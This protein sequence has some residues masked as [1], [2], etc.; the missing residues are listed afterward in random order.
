MKTLFIFLILLAGN[1]YA[2]SGS[3]SKISA[4]GYA[5]GDIS[6][7]QVADILTGQPGWG[8]H[9]G[10]ETTFE[11][12][13]TAT[14]RI[15]LKVSG[16][17]KIES[18]CNIIEYTEG[19]QTSL[20]SEEIMSPDAKAVSDQKVLALTAFCF[21]NGKTEKTQKW[22]GISLKYEMTDDFFYIIFRDG[23]QINKNILFIG[24]PKIK[25]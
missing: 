12:D 8:D 11:L 7:S 15:N 22:V 18:Q 23:D 24:K 2:K 5:Y 4:T 10:P 1:V 25:R 3:I 16:A 6:D 9:G 19:L 21:N 20:I 17:H 14:N 13:L